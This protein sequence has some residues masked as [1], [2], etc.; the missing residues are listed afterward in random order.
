MSPRISSS[1]TREGVRD[2]ERRRY[3]GLDQRLVH[4]RE[5]RLVRKLLAAIDAE[6]G[7]RLKSG[8]PILDLPSGYGRFS[9]ILAETGGRVFNSDL[10]FEMVRRAAETSGRPSVVSDAQRGLP[11]RDGAFTAIF[12]M[13]LFHHLHDPAE[14]RAVLAEFARVSS[15]WAIVSYYRT[16]A[17]HKA[18]R[19]LR[20]LVKKN[21]R[22]IRLINKDAFRAEASAAGWE[23]VRD[24]P[25]FR[26]LHA[27]RL[28]LLRKSP[29]L[30]RP[31]WSRP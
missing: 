1:F 11:F 27:A 19:A 21:P 12:S 26:G 13:R 3:R 2:Y 4:G 23:V 25:L 17:L 29:S 15:E 16:N 18:Q 14:R 30:S 10:S 28:T 5:T 24:A 31:S 9:S 7:D 8:A 22:K 20:R 6:T